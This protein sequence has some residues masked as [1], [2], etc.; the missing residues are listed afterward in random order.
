[1]F[2]G[3]LCILSEYDSDVAV[4]S[5]NIYCHTDVIL[6]DGTE[7]NHKNLK[8]REICDSLYNSLM[9]ASWSEEFSCAQNVCKFMIFDASLVAAYFRLLGG[10]FLSQKGCYAL[11]ITGKSA[12]C[13]CLNTPFVECALRARFGSS[14]KD[15]FDD[16]MD[17][18]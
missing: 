7:V 5:L 9:V 1:M 6:H 16:G 11:S 4:K 18:T 15:A 14:F 3:L 8:T 12:V 10:I 17:W 2:L 13:D